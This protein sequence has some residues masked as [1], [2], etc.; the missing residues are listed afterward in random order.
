MVKSLKKKKKINNISHEPLL[1][2]P[3]F[4]MNAQ[5]EMNEEKKNRIE[6]HFLIGN[7]LNL[8]F[9]NTLYCIWTTHIHTH[10][11]HTHIYYNR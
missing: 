1:I 6:T 11:T 10:I 8:F 7:V 3:N 9:C 4:Q 5:N 2:R